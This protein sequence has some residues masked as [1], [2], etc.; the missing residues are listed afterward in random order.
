MTD[1]QKTGCETE[2]TVNEE[3]DWLSRQ[4]DRKQTMKQY[5]TVNQAGDWLSGQR[6]RKQAV[7]QKRQ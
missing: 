4:R 6:D 2:A 3:D 1:G 5:A 7:R